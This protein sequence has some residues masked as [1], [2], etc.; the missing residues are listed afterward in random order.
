M[1]AIK[2][3]ISNLQV[4]SPQEIRNLKIF[5]LI[6]N[7][8][9]SEPYMVLDEALSEGQV[10]I[11]EVSS[12]G[13][14]PTIKFTNHGSKPVLILDGEELVGCKQNRVVNLTILA[15]AKTSIELPVSC[16]EMGR[17]REESSSFS[18]S[19]QTLYAGLRAKKL[20]SVSSS[21]QNGRY[22]ESDQ[23]E[24]WDDISEKFARMGSRSDSQAMSD[25]FQSLRID[26]DD[27]IKSIYAIDGQVGALFELNGQFAGI[28][29][30]DNTLAFTHYLPKIAAG[31]AID[32]IETLMD[33]GG[34]ITNY[35]EHPYDF[36]RRIGEM[37]CQTFPAIGIG[38]DLRFSGS[39]LAGAALEVDSNFIHF[40]AFAMDT[41][42]SRKRFRD[43]R[44]QMNIQNVSNQS[45]D[46]QGE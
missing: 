21:M 2:S 11:S 30:F 5:P 40:C 36:M 31:Y 24:I 16:V 6:G 3:A 12:A 26:I 43:L 1:I 9:T 35:S 19:K 46:R 27:Y 15:P 13:R 41:A 33:G 32:A 42:R 8:S 7:P 45:G 25:M 37:D 34:N 17:W 29:L 23:G 38:R 18:V 39:E 14:V 4:G 44:E 10:N 20:S 28:D 22:A